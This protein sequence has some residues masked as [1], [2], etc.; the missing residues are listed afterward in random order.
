MSQG[1]PLAVW[2]RA[3]AALMRAQIAAPAVV[4]TSCFRRDAQCWF[5]AA[6][7]IPFISGAFERD[8]LLYREKG[9]YGQLRN[10]YARLAH[11]VAELHRAPLR[12][13][14]DALWLLRQT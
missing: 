8:P 6:A 3:F 4:R 13:Q 5:D 9:M 14:H 10:D 1:L 2:V 7:R 11:S 12:L